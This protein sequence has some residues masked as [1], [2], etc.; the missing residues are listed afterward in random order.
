MRTFLGIRVW[1]TAVAAVAAMYI[2][3]GAD[4]S[5]P[6]SAG[7]LAVLGVD[8]TRKRGIVSATQRFVASVVGLLIGTAL[9]LLFGF[10]TW[11]IGL[12]ILL[13]YPLLARVKLKDG[14]ITS[15]VI[16]L[17]VFTEGRVHMEILLNEIVLLVIGLGC[18]TIVNMI[19][20]PGAEDRLADMRVR[21]EMLFSAIFQAFARHL[22]N[23]HTMWDGME[24]SDAAAAVERGLALATR[25]DENSLF[26]HEQYWQVYFHMRRTQLESIGRM[27]GMVAQIYD[28]LPQAVLTAQVFEELSEDVKADVYTGRAEAELKEL[29]AVF[30]AMALPA[31]REEF[32]LRSA[33]LQLCVELRTYLETAKREKKGR[34]SL[35]ST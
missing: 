3:N 7:L 34:E 22:R 29:E 17:H 28:K 35:K 15:S 33:V 4:L 16:V 31:T 6:L 8:V 10:Q 23:P 9:F 11:V 20:M 12:F 24:Y 13:A 19:Y 27:M 1:K 21:T 14:I 5:Y 26:R 18:A 30:R 32:E 25:A 2:A